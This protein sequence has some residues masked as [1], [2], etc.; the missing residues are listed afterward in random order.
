[1]LKRPRLTLSPTD[2]KCCMSC[3]ELLSLSFV[4]NMLI[5]MAT[6]EYGM[7]EVVSIYGTNHRV[8]CT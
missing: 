4:Y 5:Y 1:M 6:L 2:N 3:F 7:L 8:R